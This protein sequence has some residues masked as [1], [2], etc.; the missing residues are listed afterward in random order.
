MLSNPAYQLGIQPDRGAHGRIWNHPVAT[1]VATTP[2]S[3]LGC[4]IITGVLAEALAIADY[5]ARPARKS[6]RLRGA[7]CA[8]GRCHLRIPCRARGR[9]GASFGTT[10]VAPGSAS[11]S[12]SIVPVE[13]PPSDKRVA[14]ILSSLVRIERKMY[15]LLAK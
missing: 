10:Q 15:P 5:V 14:A 12:R 13:V 3:S 9:R 11:L 2:R 4:V 6:M 1:T 7:I 8:T